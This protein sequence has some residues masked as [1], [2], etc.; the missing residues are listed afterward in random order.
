MNEQ[1]LE[2]SEPA[3][4][5]LDKQT[6]IIVLLIMSICANFL[7]LLVLIF[8]N[9]YSSRQVISYIR[10]QQ[11]ANENRVDI[12]LSKDTPMLGAESA[13]VTIVEYA[14]F[15]CPFCAKFH[16]QVFPKLK[17]T[18]IDTGKVKFYFQNFAFLG[19]ES[20]FAA[21]AGM[22]AA[23]QGKFWPFHD[24][25]FTHHA[26]E[27]KGA[28]APEKLKGFASSVGLDQGQF[29]TCVDSR[30]NKAAVEAQTMSGVEYGVT[31][32]P[33]LFI[34]GKRY[35]G[36]SSFTFYSQKIENELK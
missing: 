35:E 32:T 8:F 19:P 36:A 21:E 20:S 29:S 6:I 12:E 1:N 25:I 22:C 26:G 15:Q 9:I 3:R 18:Y 27:N 17:E 4:K 5:Q 11:M 28:F 16:E 7:G 24:Y 23:T 30:S 13:P 14:D 33:T 31:S 10:D 34:N 2:Q